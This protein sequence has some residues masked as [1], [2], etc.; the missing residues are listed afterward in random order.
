METP[1]A[2]PRWLRPALAAVVFVASAT[3]VFALTGDIFHPSMDEGIYLEGAERLLA[4]EVPYRDFF[5]FT[6]PLV[7]QIQAALQG[8]FGKNLPMLRLSVAVSFGLVCLGVF[9]LA[10]RL[11]EWR[12]GIVAAFTLFSFSIYSL[13]R[14]TIGH[15][16][17]SAGLFMTGAWLLV[18][19][20]SEESPPRWK[21]L[22]AGLLLAAAA[23]TTTSFVI[24]L[25]LLFVGIL[26]MPGTRRRIAIPFTT[27]ALAFSLP[28]VGWLISQGALGPMLDSLVWASSRYAQA[29]AVPY[30]YY[31]GGLPFLK[32]GLS[33]FQRLWSLAISL[34]L[35]LP[36][37]GLP[38]M[39]AFTF[40]QAVRRPEPVR[41]LL[42]LVAAGLFITSWP[43]WDVNQLLYV[44]PL[45]F[46]LGAVWAAR[47]PRLA[48]TTVALIFC[49]GG[50]VYIMLLIQQTDHFAI[51]PT[52]VGVL[53]HL[54][55][56]ADAYEKLAARVPAGASAFT[57]PYMPVLGYV[58]DT[59]NPT[60]Y[61]YL[62]P[63]M[64]SA[65]DEARALSQLQA[66]PPKYILWQL[67]PEDQVLTVWPNSD[68]SRLRFPSISAFIDANYR[69]I[70]KV[71][72]LSFQITVL[73]L[74]TPI[75]HL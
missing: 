43:R 24:P 3:A 1:S 7:Y 65:A 5:A 15:R 8:I 60:A 34:R 9:G 45:L 71:R 31:P 50:L 67:L 47:L 72:A 29:N 74:V 25:V 20:A 48:A 13:Y 61:S 18:E 26:S 49:G 12:T 4:G 36:A 11:A 51:F 35:V 62:Q 75:P 2:G 54:P 56:S 30:G 6:G 57:F 52:R 46:A 38:V 33:T 58:L 66:H 14:F 63:G 53:R 42:G 19:S 37:V 27:G 39:V 40:W 68:R 21:P 69:E 23:G 10:S 64:M 73:E 41:V 32:P 17:L 59:R 16:W 22:L 55:E 28:E 70:D 44:A